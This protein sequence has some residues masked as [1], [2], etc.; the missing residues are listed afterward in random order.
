[1]VIKKMR[2]IKIFSVIFFLITPINIIAT[3]PIT[4]HNN[5]NNISKATT[6]EYILDQHQDISLYLQVLK[7]F[8]KVLP[9]FL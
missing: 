7:T 9:I 1:M 2:L 6:V 8:L 3:E 4:T 5:V